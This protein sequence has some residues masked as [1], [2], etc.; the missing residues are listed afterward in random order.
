[1]LHAEGLQLK[2]EQFR[3]N[4]SGKYPGSNAVLLSAFCGSG[5]I[6]EEESTAWRRESMEK[7]WVRGRMALQHCQILPQTAC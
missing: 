1:M 5:S 6:S 3:T 2:H 4:G 7:N